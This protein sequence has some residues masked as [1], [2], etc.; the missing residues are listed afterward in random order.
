MSAVA[1]L[2]W[3]GRFAF[4]ALFY[5]LIFN[6]YRALVKGLLLPA[7]SAPDIA[8]SGCSPLHEEGRLVLIGAEG[9][10]T[11]WVE[12]PDGKERRL[13]EGAGVPVR[14]RLRVGRGKG[15]DVRILDP[16]ISFYHF[17][18][19][20]LEGGYALEDLQTTNGTRVD[21]LPVKGSVR[22]RAG[23]RIDVGAVRFRFEVT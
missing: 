3:V 11:V 16:H 2:L 6:L 12:E 18:I 7:G 1:V 21:G 10:A 20:R 5:Y 13:G 14:A 23:S 15:N 22:L 17:V 4:L 8:G 19:H 9:D